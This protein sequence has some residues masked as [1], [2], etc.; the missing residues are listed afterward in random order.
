MKLI[1]IITIIAGT[2]FIKPDPGK[3]N[4]EIFARVKFSERYFKTLNEYYLV[5]LLDSR[6]RAYEGKEFILTG[7]Y[8]P[9]ELDDN[10][11][12]IISR[13]P[14]AQCFF[15]GGAGPESVAEIVFAGKRARLKAD[16]I[17][18]VKG[19]LVLNGTDVEHMNFILKNAEIVPS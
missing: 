18:T 12:I 19:T 9:M 5:P 3:D 7:H 4:W 11:V 10:K 17:I 8:L 16:Q 15:C 2:I 6:I 1:S 14:Y 13:F